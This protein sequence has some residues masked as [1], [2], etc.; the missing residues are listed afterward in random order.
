VRLHVRVN[1]TLRYDLP[2]TLCWPW[3]KVAPSPD[4][5]PIENVWRIVKRAIAKKPIARSVVELQQVRMRGTASPCAPLADG[6]P[7]RVAGVIAA[8]GGHTRY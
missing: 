7:R 2:E 8:K 4:L 1:K 5:N 3:R 6:M